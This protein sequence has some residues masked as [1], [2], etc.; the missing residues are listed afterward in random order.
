MRHAQ[1][2][3]IF[4]VDDE[5][6]IA[7]TLAIIF[8]NAGYDAAAYY[9][10]VSALAACAVSGPDVLLSDVTM[11]GINGI[12]LAILIQRRCPECKVLLFSG[13]VGSFELVEQAKR[14]GYRFEFFEKPV[15]P[16]ELLQRVAGTFRDGSPLQ[17]PRSVA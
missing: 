8:R 9:D 4:I 14:R 12:D 17:F 15:N 7:D 2:R 3:R 5:R 13:L 16:V 6:S 1:S 11:P 10:G